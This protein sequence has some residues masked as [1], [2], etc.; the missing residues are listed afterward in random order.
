MSCNKG[1]KCNVRDC[2]FNRQGCECA[3]E[4]IEVSRGLDLPEQEKPLQS[5]HFCKSYEKSCCDCCN[6]NKN[7][8]N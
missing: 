5:P 3:K 1:V 6:E 7:D 2:K 8:M 4:M